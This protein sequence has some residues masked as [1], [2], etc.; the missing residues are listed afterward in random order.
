[1]LEEFSSKLGGIDKL[2][3]RRINSPLTS[4]CGRLFDAVSSLLGLCHFNTF[5][6]EAAITLEMAMDDCDWR[7]YPYTLGRDERGCYLADFTPTIK[8]IVHDLTGGVAPG[9]ISARFHHTVIQLCLNLVA[10]LAADTGITKV[11]ISGGV[12]QNNFLHCRLKSLL[13]QAGFDVYANTFTPPND[14]GISLGQAVMAG[15]ILQSE[16]RNK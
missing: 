8:A 13:A 2:I 15:L 16:D 7:P 14:G 1:M 3:D 9:L 12:F 5:E 11:V 10:A 6:G 4:S